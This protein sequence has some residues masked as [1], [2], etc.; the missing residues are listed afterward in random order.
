M[1]TSLVFF[2]G[3]TGENNSN[4][5]TTDTSSESIKATG[6]EELL[7]IHAEYAFCYDTGAYDPTQ[8]YNCELPLTYKECIEWM[9]K[10]EGQ[11]STTFYANFTG[12]EPTIPGRTANEYYMTVTYGEGKVEKT[13]R[14]AVFKDIPSEFMHYVEG[15]CYPNA[16]IRIY[17]MNDELMGI[18][19]FDYTK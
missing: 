14:S 13:D 3:C 9:S 19:S 17:N 1:F 11:G 2:S 4:E 8:R 7:D 6:G 15:N 18:M 10:E 12:G 16:T 5:S